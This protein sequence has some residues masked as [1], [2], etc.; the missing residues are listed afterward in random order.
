MILGNAQRMNT[1]ATQVYADAGKGT[2]TIETLQEAFNQIDEAMSK[3]NTF[4]SEAVSKIKN[5]V[6]TLKTITHK[7]EDKIKEAEEIESF[8]TPMSLDI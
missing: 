7:L 2:I 8:K 1:Q 5:E 4:K 6:G 3:I